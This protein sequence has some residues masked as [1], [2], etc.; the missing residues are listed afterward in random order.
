MVQ[1]PCT[2]EHIDPIIK[3]DHNGEAQAI[4]ATNNELISELRDFP[5]PPLDVTGN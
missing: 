3:E 2:N 1:I 5:D 4:A